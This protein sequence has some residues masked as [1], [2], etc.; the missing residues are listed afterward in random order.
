[1]T[2]EAKS[3]LAKT[4]RGGADGGLRQRLLED[5]HNATEAAYRLG[6]RRQDAG[7]DEAASARRRRLEAWI[8]DQGRAQGGTKEPRTAE[9]HRRD[10]EKQ[11]AYTWLNRIVVLRLM[12]A[13]GLRAPALVTGGW[14]SRGY[15]DFR[16]IAPALVR[17]DETEGYA[18]LLGLTFEDLATELPGIFG[19]G[20]VADLI[21]MPAATLRHLVESLD[22]E[23]LC[24]CWTDDMTLGW[25]YQ[26]WNDPEREAL[27]AKLN[28][29]GKV[30]PHEIASK[31]QMFTERYMV[32]WLLQNSLGPMWL[33]MCRKHGWTAEV[34]QRHA[35]GESF[36]DRLEARRTDWR[37]KRA[38]GEVEL[39]ELMP[40]HSEAERRWAYY[41]PQPIPEDAVAQAPESVRDLKLLDPA[42]GSGH[43]LVVAFELLVALYREEARHRGEAGAERW[44]DAAL[45]ERILEHNLH[46]IDL[47]PRAV[48][49]AAAALWLKA[50]GV[51][52]AARPSRMNLVAAN[53]RLSSLPEHDPALVELRRVVED[54]TGIP[55]ALTNTIIEAL[56]GAD[57]PGS[58]GFHPPKK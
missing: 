40:L 35:E 37:A 6:V 16:A 38:A 47:D 5:L 21:P 20:G 49:I 4:I 33:A 25:V 44:G 17:G 50:K 24:T 15:K 36:L 41:V 43:F 57:H 27:D 12:E 45:V 22:A 52:A 2:P 53:L 58:S 48:Q 54:D 18:F 1:M 14:E 39:T 30:A 19:G 3:A 7:L 32:D 29:G 51:C 34:E 26:Y 9:D 13:S 11:A 31:T 46:G 10:A 56:K 8:G 55:A 23:A 42:V 28:S